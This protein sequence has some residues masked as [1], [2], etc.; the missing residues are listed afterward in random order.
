SDNVIRGG[1]TPKHIDVAELL[2]ILDFRT[3]PAP[4][5]RPE[6]PAPGVAVFRPDVPDFVLTV[7]SP[8]AA[9]AGADVAI[10]GGGPAIAFA[11]G[12][13][14]LDSGDAW[15]ALEPGGAAYLA[16]VPKVHVSGTARVF[17]VN[18]G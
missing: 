13:A 7:V 16:D 5:L 17:L 8:D 11:G 2:E 6:Q 3:L 14:V 12:G 1:L 9:A 15:S 10:P 4:Y 18:A